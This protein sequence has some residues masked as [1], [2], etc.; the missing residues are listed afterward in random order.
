MSIKT[1]NIFNHQ[2]DT[3][4][5]ANYGARLVKWITLVDS[6]PRNVILAYD[7]LDDYLQDPFYIGA[8][9][10]PYANRIASS[11]CSINGHSLQLD[12]NEGEHHLHGGS[13]AT[14][15][16]FWECI[17]HD[18]NAVTLQCKLADDFNGYPGPM[19]IIVCYKL[20]EDG[21][22]ST[23]I[24]VLSDKET[25]AGPTT[26]PYF[27]LN[28]DDEINE[29]KA[30][31]LQLFSGHFT[32][33]DNAGLPHGDITA[34]NGTALDYSKNRAI[35]D[36]AELDH[37]FLLVAEDTTQSTNC[38]THAILQSHDKKLRLH[39]SSNYPAMQVYTGQHLNA[40]FS[41]YQGVCLEPQFCPDSPNQ[42]SF[43]FHLTTEQQPLSTKII[44]RL[45]KTPD[46]QR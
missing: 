11:S 37:N 18:A 42:S 39:V 41:A 6:L 7:K 23:T 28:Q 36:K 4:H 14:A 38:L 46:K 12:A 31:N 20:L 5:I 44:Y 8:I 15:N 29:N 1:Y 33:V 25:I 22:L 19:T 9:V 10:G 40:P 17:K 43:P 13:N 32:P 21:A 45:E 30:H 24:D 16:Q 34:V 3:V 2:G 26:H 27:N 35:P